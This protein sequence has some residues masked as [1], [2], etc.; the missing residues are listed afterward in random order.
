MANDPGRLPS[1]PCPAKISYVPPQFNLDYP[2]GR[3]ASSGFFFAQPKLRSSMHKL[4]LA[5]TASASG[6]RKI[7]SPAKAATGVLGAPAKKR[8]PLSS[9]MLF[10]S[11][12]CRCPSTAGAFT[13][14]T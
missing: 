8:T 6:L 1:F 10:A 11:W 13:T 4:S 2:I 5:V 3:R 9:G 14:R 7:N 12:T